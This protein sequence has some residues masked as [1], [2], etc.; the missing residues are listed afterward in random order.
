MKEK[1]ESDLRMNLKELDSKQLQDTCVGLQ[2]VIDTHVSEKGG[3]VASINQLNKQNQLLQ[4]EIARL[5]GEVGDGA[6]ASSVEMKALEEEN[7]RLRERNEKLQALNEA[8]QE[9]LI[10]G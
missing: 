6:G 8:L 4:E 7:I 2:E 5:E 10:S 9:K 1:R 3:L